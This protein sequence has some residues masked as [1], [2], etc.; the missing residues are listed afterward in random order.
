M[1]NC[2]YVLVNLRNLY[3][4]LYSTPLQLLLTNELTRLQIQHHAIVQ[5]KLTRLQH[6]AHKKRH[7]TDKNWVRNISSPPLDENETQVLSYGLKHSVTPK[8][9]PTNDIVS[10]VESVLARQ[11]ELPELHRRYQNNTNT[12]RPQACILRRQ[13]T[14]HQHT[15]STCP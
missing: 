3:Q 8:W 14:F 2:Y 4:H 5:S 7:K 10:S 11:R 9:I 1:I 12:R 6:A 15:T 13:I